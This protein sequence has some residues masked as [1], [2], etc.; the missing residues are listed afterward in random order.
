MKKTLVF[1]SLFIVWM[2][3]LGAMAQVTNSYWNGFWDNK[4]VGW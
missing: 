2:F 4:I 3:S 1:L